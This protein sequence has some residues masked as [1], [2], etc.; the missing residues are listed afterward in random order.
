MGGYKDS[1]IYIET[2]WG[3]MDFVDY[4]T[5]P[6]ND[7]FLYRTQLHHGKS[8]IFII[9]YTRDIIVTCSQDLRVKV[10]VILNRIYSVTSPVVC[11]V[12]GV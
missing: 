11:L 6:E 5:Q 10:I 1:S 9:Y 3:A 8:N 7:L 4:R 2:V 12:K